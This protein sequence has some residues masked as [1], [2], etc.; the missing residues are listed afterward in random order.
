MDGRIILDG[1]YGEGGGQILRTALALAAMVG[2]A[3]KI[4]SIRSGRRTPGLRSQHL[5]AVRAIAEV[6]SARV[7]GAEVGSRSLIFEPGKIKPNAFTLPIGTAGS[8]SLV[9][10]AILP[11]LL[12]AR[13]ESHLRITGGTHVPWSPPFHYLKEVFLPHLAEMGARVQVEIGRWGF[14][15][16]GGGEL[17]AHV[18][19]VSMLRSI[20]RNARGRL[21]EISGFSAVSNLPYS[22]GERQRVRVE[23]CLIAAGYNPSRVDLVT[24]PGTGTGTAVFLLG[25][26]EKSVSG[27]TSL[28]EKG[29]PAERVA[30]DA[31]LDFQNFMKT[32]AAVDAHLGDQ[33]LLYM[34]LA[35]GRSSLAVQE[36]TKHLLTNIWVIE[37]FLPVKFHVNETMKQVNVEGADFS[38]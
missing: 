18:S 6:S 32:E 3:V 13:G 9:L 19:P 22:I 5:M 23:K 34:A 24:A 38:F 21:E 36:I 20:E 30:E 26:F 1:S 29:K 25:R 27:F 33:L 2:K 16:R 31:F 17:E 7:G 15:P 10:Q 28:G 37:Q 4:S 12:C 14:Y 11:P 8:T 35:K